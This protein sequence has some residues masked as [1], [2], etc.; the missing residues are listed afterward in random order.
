MRMQVIMDGNYRWAARRGWVVGAGHAAGVGAL[1]RL[2]TSC[3]DRG[4][5]A[6]TVRR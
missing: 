2:I 3:S 5:P 4:I 6:L 1:K